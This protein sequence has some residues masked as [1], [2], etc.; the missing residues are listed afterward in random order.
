MVC[1][2]PMAAGQLQNAV[3]SMIR[4]SRGAANDWDFLAQV[5]YRGVQMSDTVAQM[6]QSPRQQKTIEF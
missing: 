6:S 1:T 5:G 4:R 3:R 2:A